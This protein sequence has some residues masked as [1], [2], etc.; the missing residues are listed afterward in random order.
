MVVNQERNCQSY[1]EYCQTSTPNRVAAK[2][3]LPRHDFSLTIRL[4]ARVLYVNEAQPSLLSLE[5]N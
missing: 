3:E 4:R 2:M 1:F 5:E